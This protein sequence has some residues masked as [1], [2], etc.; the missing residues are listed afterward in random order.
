MLEG[1]SFYPLQV[2]ICYFL[3]KGQSVASFEW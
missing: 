2:N 1:V 3:E